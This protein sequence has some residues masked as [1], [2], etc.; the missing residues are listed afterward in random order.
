MNILARTAT[1]PERV[2]RISESIVRASCIATPT[3]SAWNK[4]FVPLAVKRS[5]AAIL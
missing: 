2:S 5:S 1:R 3:A 4:S